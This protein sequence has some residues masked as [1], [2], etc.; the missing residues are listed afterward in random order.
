MLRQAHSCAGSHFDS[1]RARVFTNKAARS[2]RDAAER[3][4]T[5]LSGDM[6]PDRWIRLLILGGLLL[7]LGR[8]HAVEG[9]SRLR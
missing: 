9:E 3:V 5:M 8:I 1:T 4:A 2:L 7:I 6:A